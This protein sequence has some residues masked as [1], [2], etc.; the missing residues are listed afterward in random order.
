M[1][2]FDKMVEDHIAREHKPKQIGRYYPS[3]VGSCL[4]K[5]WY[6]YKYPQEVNLEL[7]KIFEVGDII[8]GFVV[9]VLKSEKNKEVEL[10][11]AEMPFQIDHKDFTISGRVD[12]LVLVKISGKKVL[13]EVK[14]TKNLSFI[15]RPQTSHLTQL[16][17]YMEA[18]GV[19]DG[20]VLYVDKNNLKSRVFEVEFDTQE[21]A[22]IF[23]RFSFLHEHL[24]ED[25]VPEPE[26]KQIEDMKWTCKYCEYK[27]K[28]DENER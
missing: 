1:F 7:R 16:M 22:D 9:E 6:S 20:V 4:R 28:C 14:T 13:V 24:K 8:H 26:A 11:E 2:D 12:D 5:V 15:E 25:R 19:H 18:T 3:E 21:A 10:L 17:F 23:D 27:E